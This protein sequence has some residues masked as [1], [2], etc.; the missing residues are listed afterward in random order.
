MIWKVLFFRLLFNQ[1]IDM[2]H[3]T[4]HF[5]LFFFFQAE[6][7]IRDLTVTG[8]Q[9]CALPI[10]AAAKKHAEVDQACFFA[11]ADHFNGMPQRGFGR[12]QERLRRAQLAYGVG[13]QCAY[14]VRRHIADALS[15]T[16]QAFQRA[17]PCSGGEATFAIQAVGHAHRLAQAVDHP[18][19]A[20]RVARDD[21]V[22]TVG[23]KVD[24]GQQVAILQCGRSRGGM[25]HGRMLAEGAVC[26]S[27]RGLHIL[28]EG[29]AA[30]LR[31][32]PAEGRA[33]ATATAGYPWDGGVGPMAGD[34][35]N[36][37]AGPAAGGWA[38][39][40]SRSSASQAKRDR[41]STRLNSSHSQISYAVFCLKKKLLKSALAPVAVFSLPV[42]L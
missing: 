28:E 38:F 12:D 8:V 41:K 25:R 37:Q 33:T 1:D 15:E 2:F 23:A 32:A 35:V 19:L 17:L 10:S 30:G 16:G 7:G 20:E 21:H 34:A 18:Q 31:P 9:T 40:R 3:L 4:M 42:V 36:P 39:G 24:G 22:E 5:F 6:D 26:S 14:P 29:S 11:A 27:P 13:G